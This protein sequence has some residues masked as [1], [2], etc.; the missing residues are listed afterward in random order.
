MYDW[1]GYWGLNVRFGPNVRSPKF[2]SVKDLQGEVIIKDLDPTGFHQSCRKLVD[3]NGNFDKQG[4]F[5]PE[6]E[7]LP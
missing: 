5:D 1:P 4:S 2:S 3:I 7:L 6:T